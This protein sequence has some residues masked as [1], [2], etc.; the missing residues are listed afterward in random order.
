MGWRALPVEIFIIYSIWLGL[1]VLGGGVVILAARRRAISP[2]PLLPLQRERAV[3]WDGFDILFIAVLV[4]FLLPGIGMEGLEQAGFYRWYYGMGLRDK[5]A[6]VERMI[7]WSRAL[8]F[9]L[10]VLLVFSLLR[11]RGRLE[12]YQLGIARPR[13]FENAVLGYVGWAVLTPLVFAVL[14]GADAANSR[15]SRSEE[16]PLAHLAQGRLPPLEWGLL[17][18][19]AV[20][21]APVTEELLFRGLIQRWARAQTWRPDAIIV[22]AFVLALTTRSKDLETAMS[23]L[24]M[25]ER[26]V[27]LVNGAMPAAF[28]LLMIPGYVYC[29]VIAWRWL[30]YP[31]AGRSIYATSLC[32]AAAHSAVWP[33]P[34]PLFVLALGLGFVAYRTQSLVPSITFHALFNLV[35]CIGMLVT[36]PEHQVKKGS[37]ETSALRRPPAT[38]TSS[39][40]PGAS[41]PRR[42]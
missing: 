11:S 34:I 14:I 8:V 4:Y 2:G 9:P 27:A 23:N 15:W 37:E 5:N 25:Q 17:F 26:M 20:V 21:A 12:L 13:L 42:M 16:H 10:Q 29:E 28:V 7:Q 40:V 33:S 35:S 38:S 3:S 30:P 6:P 18:F 41:L 31:N 19:V 36:P 24:P 32:F 22:A 39:V 1:A